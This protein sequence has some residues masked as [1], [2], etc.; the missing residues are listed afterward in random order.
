MYKLFLVLM[1]VITV[2]SANGQSITTSA[3]SNSSY[4]AVTSNESLTYSI[5]GVF[6]PGNT[7]TAQLS[8]ASGSFAVPTAIGTLVSTAAGIITITFPNVSGS[9]YRVRVV[10]DNPLVIGTDNGTDISLTSTPGDPALFG[11]S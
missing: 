3:L 1:A 9:G 6:N 10:S 8:D 4:C 7:F 11:S 5:S 2:S